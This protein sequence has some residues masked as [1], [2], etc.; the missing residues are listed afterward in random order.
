MSSRLD[1]DAWPNHSSVFGIIDLASLPKDRYY[2]YRSVW[3]KK[4]PTLH[5]LPHWNWK[6]REG[7]VTPIF[8][9][10]SYPK[11]ELFI[12]GKSCGVREKNDSTLQH[13]FRLMWNDVKYQPG[14]VKVVA[15]D[16]NGYKAMEKTLKTAG[17]PHHLVATVNH[18]ALNADGEDLAYVTVQVADKDGN[19]VPT[20]SR[21]V[22]FSVTGAGRFR[23]TANGDPTC[24]YSFQGSEMPLFSGA[25]TAIVQ[26]GKEPGKITFEARA[27]G[28][29]P[30]KVTIDVK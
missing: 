27:K 13:R 1:T 17:K 9:Y 4:E 6:G 7:E 29:K 26:A 19:I 25:L 24:L 22:K 3:N 14:E 20:D 5:I 16:T 23:A 2:L 8:V 15:Y 21:L 18:T 10:T 28:V 11:A 30:C 12:N